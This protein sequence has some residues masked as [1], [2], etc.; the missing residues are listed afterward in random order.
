MLAFAA[1]VMLAATVFS[2]LLPGLALAEPLFGSPRAGAL[3]VVA[4]MFAGGLAMSAVHRLLPH[5]H[6]LKGHDGPARERLARVWRLLLPIAVRN[7]PA[8]LSRR[9]GAPSGAAAIGPGVTLGIGLQNLPEGLAVAMSLVG[10]GS[11]RAQAF[12]VAALTG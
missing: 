5:E 3:A 8:G 10:L 6:F 9:V 12:G 1:G 7:C 11:A 4:A 2:L